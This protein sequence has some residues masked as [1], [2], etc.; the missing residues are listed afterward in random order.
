MLPELH[1]DYMFVGDEGKAG[2]TNTCLVMR[3]ASTRMTLSMMVPQKGKEDYVV[4]RVIAFLEEVGCLHG[5][6]VVKSDQESSIR[7]LVDSI[8]KLKVIRGSGR[9]IPEHSPV[10]SSASNGIAE[11]AVQSVQGQLRVIRLALEK[12]Y[13]VEIS[14]EHPIFAWALEFAAVVLNRCEVGHD[15]LTAYQRLKGKRVLMP[16]LEFGEGVIWKIDNRTGALGKL[17][18]SWKSGVYIGVRCK[19]CEFVVAD[20]SG[21]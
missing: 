19:S 18:S 8:G 4:D 9:W 10:G 14:A 11:R 12:R 20:S 16:G 2:E 5:D 3:E 1:L 7:S 21:I 6:V 15:G 17:S 13:G